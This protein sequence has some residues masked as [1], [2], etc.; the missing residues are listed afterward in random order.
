MTVVNYQ[1][2]EIVFDRNTVLTVGTYDG[3]HCGHQ[4]ILKQMRELADKSGGRVVV[5]TFHPHPQ[6]VLQ[7]EGR[8]P[9]RLLTSIDERCEMLEAMGVDV[10]VI[11]TFTREFATTPAEE[12][13]RDV[14]RKV[15]VQQFFVGH[16]H[17]FGRD[18]GGNEELLQRLSI[19]LEFEVKTLEPLQCEGEVVSSSKIRAALVSGNIESANAMLGRPYNLSGT[20]VQGDGRGRTI[21]FPTANI[22]PVNANKLVPGNGVYVVSYEFEGR[23]VKGLANIGR[24]PT[25]TTDTETTIEVHFLDLDEDLYDRTITIHFHAFIRNEKKFESAEALTE[26]IENDKQH[27]YELTVTH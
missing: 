19:E 11:I 7:R 1:S 3:V 10:T 17:M 12:F 14:A 9:V 13:V 23:I 4:G 27:A 5:V 2:D 16:D 26:Q 20:V 24:R 18:R 8:E 15:G 25:F 6:I 21:G 22:E